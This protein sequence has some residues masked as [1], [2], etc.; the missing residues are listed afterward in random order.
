[1]TTTPTQAAGV[2]ITPDMAWHIYDPRDLRE[3]RIWLPAGAI[4]EIDI[5]PSGHASI[6]LVGREMGYR[7]P[8]ADVPRVL[9]ALGIP[10]PPITDGGAP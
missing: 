10:E 5:E 7:I 4:E 3:H 9:A 2:W 8:P 1:M 6:L